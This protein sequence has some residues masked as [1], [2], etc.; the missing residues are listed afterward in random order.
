M[1]PAHSDAAAPESTS[2]N[3]VWTRS[4]EVGSHHTDKRATEF[5]IDAGH[6]ANPKSIPLLLGLTMQNYHGNLALAHKFFRSTVPGA[7]WKNPV[8]DQPNDF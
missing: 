7:L 6:R 4:I 8:V 2:L 3:T 5:A 1:Q